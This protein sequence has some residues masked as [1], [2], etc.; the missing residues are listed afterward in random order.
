M[1]RRKAKVELTL[2]PFLSVLSGL[3]AVLM[4][5]MIVTISTRVVDEAAASPAPP[6]PPEAPQPGRPGGA[7]KT[8]DEASID[9]E[10][11]EELQR[12]IDRLTAA[13]N[14]RQQMRREMIRQLLEITDLIEA[15]KIELT[16]AP[17]ADGKK[18]GV[19]LGEPTPVNVI[20]SGSVKVN[21]K[22]VFI[23]VSATG[24]IV[25]PQK[26]NL[27]PVTKANKNDPNSDFIAPA[28][29]TQFLT[30]FSK[31]D[32]LTKYLVFLIHPNGAEVFNN[33]RIHI[34][35][36]YKDAFDVGWEPFS[37]EW[38]LLAK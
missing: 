24:Y 22:P 5:F 7:Q 38:I 23:E 15:K 10:R 9:A 31:K 3:I 13:L 26:L 35:L 28:E 21:K 2:F 30:E 34:L 18:I 19:K 20:P 36:K 32:R 14:E 25:H 17:R 33:I 11:Y 1:A 8:P 12:E 4:L 16:T 6:P 29:V 27:P 37:R